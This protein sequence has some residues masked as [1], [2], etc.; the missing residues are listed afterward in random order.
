M[1]RLGDVLLYYL[2]GWDV[3][4]VVLYGKVAAC[5]VDAK[6][7]LVVN[8]NYTGLEVTAN[9]GLGGLKALVRVDLLEINTL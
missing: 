7:L 6:T 9:H 5:S 1:G 8:D 2:V 4:H 3:H